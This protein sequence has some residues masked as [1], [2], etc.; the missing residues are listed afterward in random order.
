[1]PHFSINSHWPFP[2]LVYHLVNPTI[3]DRLAV[4]PRTFAQHITALVHAGFTVVSARHAID[5]PISDSANKIVLTFDD[6]YADN[7]QWALPVLAQRTCSAT[8]FLS[9]AYIGRENL[10]NHRAQY[11]VRHASRAELRTWIKAGMDVQCHGHD[12][13]CFL[14]LTDIELMRNLQRSVRAIHSLTTVTPFALAYPFGA[15]NRRVR[16]VAKAMFSHAFAVG[17]Q[18]LA[19]PHCLPRL[20]VDRDVRP[21]ELVAWVRGVAEPTGFRSRKYYM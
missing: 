16:K 20:Y 10:W 3:R 13:Q 15:H 6:G 12:H 19:D 18:S 21:Q 14:K 2:T 1:M 11:R 17:P 8:I 7:V 4:S 9:T 5:S